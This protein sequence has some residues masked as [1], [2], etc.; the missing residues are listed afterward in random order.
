MSGVTSDA[1]RLTVRPELRDV[2]MVLAFEGWN[3]AGQAA[4]SAVQFVDRCIRSAPLAE[5]DCEEFY[6]FTVCRP[7]VSRGE[8]GARVIEWPHTRFRFGS[9]D[10]SREIVVGWGSEPHL[11]WQRYCDLVAELVQTLGVHRVVLLGAYLADVV[12]SR[13]VDVTGFSS[14]P[15]LL[16]S[17]R[18]PNSDY[19]GP[20]GIVGVLADRLRLDGVEVL[21]LWAGLPHYISASPNPRAALALVRKLAECL[22]LKLDAEPLR[23]EAAR[24]E[25]RISTLVADDPE[26]G[27]YV[28]QLKRREFAQ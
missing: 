25:E 11:R 16:E 18:V 21:S 12:Y 17:L 2:Q 3:D 24:F 22:D 19:E 10:D 20:T 14:S 5:L 7:T 26:L 27:E 23:L 4:T 15:A 1:L 13:P 6:D 28:R 9:I 8:G